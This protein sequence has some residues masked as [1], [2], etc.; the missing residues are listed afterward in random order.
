M[1]GDARTDNLG[2]ADRHGFAILLCEIARN[3]AVVDLI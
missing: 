3:E 1:H 2:K